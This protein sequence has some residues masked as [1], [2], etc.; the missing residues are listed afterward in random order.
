MRFLVLGAGRQGSACALDLLRQEDVDAVTLADRDPDAGADLLPDDGRLSRE[1]VDLSDG[2]ALAPLVSRHDV[3]LS[4]APYLFNETTA[5]VAI[6][7]GSHYADLGGNTEIVFRQ[8][9]MDGRAR[10]QGVTV[11]PDVGLAPGLVNVLAAEGARRLDPARSIRM[12]VGGLPRDPKPPL[13]YMIVY[14]LR[15]T[16]DYYTTPATVLRNGEPLEMPALSEVETIEFPGLGE[17]EAFHTAGGVSTMPWR[18]RDRLETLE[19]RTL[20]YP[21]HAAVMRGVRDL[22]LLDEEPVAVDGVEVAP[23]EVFL[24]CAEPRLRMPDEPDL[25]A[26]RV[27]AEGRRQG[28]PATLTWELLDRVERGDRV[29]AMM[30]CTGYSL[31]VV[32]LLLGRGRIGESG[33]FPPDRALPADEYL[34]E[35]AARG[36]EVRLREEIA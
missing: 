8:L 36:V 2:T 34:A 5:R 15:G 28:R 24:A 6:E 25:V 14:S 10:E 32:G 13:D 11:V 4:A 30:R 7:C 12:Y 1:V 17:L 27:V 33:V 9:E 21:G 29:T 16:I 26:L 31:S 35:L 22:G 18:Y 20:R 23:R 3:T 19:Y